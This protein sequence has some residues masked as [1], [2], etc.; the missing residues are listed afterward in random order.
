MLPVPS[1]A[2]CAE[3]QRLFAQFTIAVSAYLRA[4]S[5]Q[6][7]SVVL[8]DGFGFEDQINAATKRKDDAKRAIQEHQS[9]HG[10]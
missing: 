7:K 4:Q 10:C 1:P 8:G 6:L 3:K 9:E 5:E 2:F